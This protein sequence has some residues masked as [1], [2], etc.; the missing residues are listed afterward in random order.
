MDLLDPLVDPAE[1]FVSTGDLPPPGRVARLVDDAHLRFGSVA[2]G[3]VSNV[4]PAL[5]R[6]PPEL[7]GICVV[8]TDGRVHA[9]GDAEHEFTIMSVSKPFLFA[10]ICDRI[11]PTGARERLGM[12]AT[13]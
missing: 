2:L 8:G 1:G 13:G 5:A 4:Y 12:N 9:V 11:G 3:Q 6:V 10:L 7:F